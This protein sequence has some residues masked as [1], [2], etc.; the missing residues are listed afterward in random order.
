MHESMK[1]FQSAGEAAYSAAAERTGCSQP[2]SEA[3][4]EKWEEAAA[5][6]IMFGQQHAAEAQVAF[7]KTGSCVPYSLDEDGNL[8]TAQLV[9]IP[10]GTIE[11]KVN[12]KFI[13]Y[14]RCADMDSAINEFADIVM[15]P[16]GFVIA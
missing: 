9:S 6:A 1:N 16:P 2:W 12:G 14:I 3:N 13:R 4:Q 15:A 11:I 8:F 7:F 5:A 10:S